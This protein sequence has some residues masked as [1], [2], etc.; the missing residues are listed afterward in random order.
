MISARGRT[1]FRLP[2]YVAI[3][4]LCLAQVF[5][6][7]PQIYPGG[8]VNPAT[9]I[10]EVS[11]GS[12]IVIYGSGLATTISAATAGP[13]PTRLDGTQVFVNGM[14]AP[15]FFVTPSQISAQIPWEAN[16][17]VALNI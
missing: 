15:L 4:S 3:L 16:T 17:A 9:N 1:M 2:L 5:A 12:L 11:P 6:Q 8:V 10:G 7:N 14:A 13:W